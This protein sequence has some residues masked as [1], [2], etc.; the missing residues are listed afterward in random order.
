M[1]QEEARRLER[2]CLEKV[3]RYGKTGRGLDAALDVLREYELVHDSRKDYR[4]LYRETLAARPWDECPCDICQALGV[5]VVLFR[6]AERKRRRGFHN[7]FVTY[8]RL[9]GE[10]AEARRALPSARRKESAR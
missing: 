9:R 4:K 5:H 8:R 2:A 6:G 10:G 1:K 3:V 7:L